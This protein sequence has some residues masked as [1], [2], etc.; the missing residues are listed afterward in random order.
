M[1][2]TNHNDCEGTKNGFV[3]ILI[4][5]VSAPNAIFTCRAGELLL[6]FSSISLHYEENFSDLLLSDLFVASFFA[7]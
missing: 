4:L 1:W 6:I 3:P 5:P 7:T 2:Y